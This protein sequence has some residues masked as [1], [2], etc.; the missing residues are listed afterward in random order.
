MVYHPLLSWK[1]REKLPNLVLFFS[2]LNFVVVNLS[3][4]RSPLRPARPSLSP[5][6]V[7]GPAQPS[8]SPPSTT[9]SAQPSLSPP[10]VT[11]PG[12]PSICPPSTT[13][14]AQPSLPPP[15]ATGSI[16]HSLA[17]FIRPRSAIEATVPM[18]RAPSQPEPDS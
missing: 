12:R 9:D 5:P 14:P 7:T 10:T 3:K 11:G 18:P 8:L 15:N 13:G 6:T 1:Q 17:R 16:Q 4:A 2:V